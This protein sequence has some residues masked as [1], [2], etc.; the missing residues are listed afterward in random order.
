MPKGTVYILLNPKF[1]DLIKIGRTSRDPNKRVKELSRQTGVPADFII[2]YDE[3]VNNC[4][5]I[6]TLMHDKF[7]GYREVRNKEFFRVRPKEA[8]KA[9]IEYAENSRVDL[10]SIQASRNML[11]ELSLKYPTYLKKDIIS[12]KI[13]HYEDLCLLETVRNPYQDLGDRISET[14]DLGIFFETPFLATKTPDDN[15]D[16]FINKLNPYDIIMTTSIFDEESC[17]KIAREFES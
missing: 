15:A 6:E 14:I 7:A 9:L 17:Q 2:I 10:S 5:E 13:F 3:L 11:D 8:I 16:V 1:P 12:V 4:E